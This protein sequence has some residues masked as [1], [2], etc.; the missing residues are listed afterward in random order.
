MTT[1]ASNRTK[2]WQS[3]DNEHHLHPFTNHPQLRGKGVRMITGAKG[4]YLTDSEGEQLLDGMAGL[5]CTQI[6][7]GR[8]EIADVAAKTMK[9]LSYYNLFFM[10]SHPYATELAAKVAEKAPGDISQILFACSGSEAVDSAFKLIKYYWNLKGQPKRKH[11][12]ARE[13][14]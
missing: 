14:A 10:T 4:I 13:G 5:W 6:G 12:V 8:E 7:Y 2:F 11:F 9:E 1:T 3:Q